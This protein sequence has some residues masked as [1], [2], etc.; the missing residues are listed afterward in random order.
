MDKKV[1]GL[2]LV[3]SL[4]AICAQNENKGIEIGFDFTIHKAPYTSYFT[5]LNYPVPKTIHYNFFP[6]VF[7]QFT[8]KHSIG[9]IIGMGAGK[10]NYYN[11]L[12]GIQEYFESQ[13]AEIDLLYKNIMYQLNKF[14][15]FVQPNLRF[16]FNTYAVQWYDVNSVPKQK[17]YLD[18]LAI[19][20]TKI[21][22][23]IGFNYHLKERF[24]IAL[25]ASNNIVSRE[26]IE[27]GITNK[28]FV[29]KV[30]WIDRYLIFGLGLQYQFAHNKNR[31][32]N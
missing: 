18:G 25:F 2:L 5:S 8:S 12:H 9:L 14:S 10:S 22:C 7:Y 24:N 23:R 11:A 28:T 6:S 1:L 19:F 3:L 32:N 16:C 20:S 29:N 26:K 4:K 30:I 17:N 13:S 21:N 31:N 15:L 27:Y